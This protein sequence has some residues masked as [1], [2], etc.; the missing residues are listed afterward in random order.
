MVAQSPI[1]LR[2]CLILFSAV[3]HGAVDH[4]SSW[5]RSTKSVQERATNARGSPSLAIRSTT[6]NLS[7]TVQPLRNQCKMLRSSTCRAAREHCSCEAWSVSPFFLEL[8]CADAGLP[9]F[10]LCRSVT[11][12][13]QPKLRNPYLSIPYRACTVAPVRGALIDSSSLSHPLNRTPLALFD[14]PQP[15]F[16]HLVPLL[17]RPSA[18]LLSLLSCTSITARRSPSISS[19]LHM[20][21]MSLQ[22]LTSLCPLVQQGGPSSLRRSNGPLLPGNPLTVVETPSHRPCRSAKNA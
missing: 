6:G 18:C 7:M 17:S 3:I 13:P 15:L 21:R 14:V 9:L 5:K 4:P 8:A 22:F 20:T 10:C 12:Q 19:A 2:S 11:R 1:Q 16:R